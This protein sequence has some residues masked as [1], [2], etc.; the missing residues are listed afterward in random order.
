MG[1]MTAFC[2]LDCEK[3]DAYIATV[4]DDEKL[5]E[6]TAKL[7]SELNNAPILPEHI[8]CGGCR[9]NGVKTVYCESICAVRKCALAKGVTTCGE[10]ADFENC[11]ILAP[12]LANS[13]S[14]LKNLRGI[15]A[16][17]DGTSIYQ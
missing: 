3:C 4:N 13:P 9:T 8:N 7:W 6:K 16:P 11:E 12:I 10:C 14:A 2:G 1:K 17:R 5:R 15:S